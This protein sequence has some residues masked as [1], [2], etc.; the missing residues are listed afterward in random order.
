MVEDPNPL[1]FRV[2]AE[3]L[4]GAIE[5]LHALGGLEQYPE[6]YQALILER[7]RRELQSPPQEIRL[8]REAFAALPA[9]VRR[10]L[11]AEQT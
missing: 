4:H 5:A 10:L 7:S 2:S 6:A 3:A 11:T 8:T 9:V 1:A